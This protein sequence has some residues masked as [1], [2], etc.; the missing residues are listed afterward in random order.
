[1]PL[2][3]IV[4]AAA[5]YLYFSQDSEAQAGTGELQG[6]L[7]GYDG[8]IGPQA[9]N[10]VDFG[11]QQS[12]DTWAEEV[13][14]QQVINAIQSWS[15]TR[16][17]DPRLTAAIVRTESSFRPDVKNPADPSYGLMGVTPLIAHAYGGWAKADGEDAIKQIDL[18]VRAGTGFL[19]HLVDRYGRLEDAIQAYNLG[20]TKFDQGV[21]V[22]DYL[23][24][25][26]TA[27]NRYGGGIS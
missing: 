24:K 11:G 7:L 8:P 15:I 10:N 21:R 18:N 16:G 17:L 22:P 3:L 23:S 5:A 13:S 1:M 12:M 26:L 20:E 14:N 19:R 6:P 4:A 9:P 25:V 2:V 27:F